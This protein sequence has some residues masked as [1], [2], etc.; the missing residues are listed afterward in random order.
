MQVAITGWQGYGESNILL[1]FCK[2]WLFYW[3]NIKSSNY[4]IIQPNLYTHV[5]VK[6]I[7]LNNEGP[8]KNFLDLL[9]NYTKHDI[10]YTLGNKQVPCHLLHPLHFPHSLTNSYLHIRSTQNNLNQMNQI[11]KWITQNMYHITNLFNF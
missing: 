1:H 5:G 2:R 7:N 4:F 3:R 9:K 11:L 10:F 6:Y 8:Y